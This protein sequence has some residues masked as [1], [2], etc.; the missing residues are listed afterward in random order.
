MLGMGDHQFYALADPERTIT[1]TDET[2]NI[3]GP[4]MLTVSGEPSLTRLDPGGI[5]ANRRSDSVLNT[6]N[7]MAMGPESCTNMGDAFSPAKSPWDNG[8]YTYTY[9][10]RIPADYPHDVVRVEL[11]DPDSIN[12]PTQSHT[13]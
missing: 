3:A 10:I 2:N 13:I 1:E 9:R 7:L 8:L 5:Y 6:Q 4:V 12:Q 11:F